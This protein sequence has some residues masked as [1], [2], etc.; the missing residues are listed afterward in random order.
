MSLMKKIYDKHSIKMCY[1]VSIQ[2]SINLHSE[3]WIDSICASPISI[4]I[5]FHQ[6]KFDHTGDEN[7]FFIMAGVSLSYRGSCM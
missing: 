6:A 5:S 2:S 3:W 1:F 7:K 4:A